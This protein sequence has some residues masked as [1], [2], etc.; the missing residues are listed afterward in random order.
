MMIKT[1][2][3]KSTQERVYGFTGYTYGVIANGIAVTIEAGYYPFFEIMKEDVD[4]D[5]EVKIDE[6]RFHSDEEKQDE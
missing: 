2:I 4:W 3:R 6:W 1:G 5:G